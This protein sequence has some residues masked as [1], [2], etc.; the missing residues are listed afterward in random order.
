MARSF[1]APRHRRLLLAALAFALAVSLDVSGRDMSVWAQDAPSSEPPPAATPP[2]GQKSGEQKPPERGDRA[3]TPASAA[4]AAQHRL[5]PDSTTQQTL[6]LAGRTLAFAATAGSIRLFDDKGEPQAD[7]AYTA[8]QLDGADPATRPVTFVFNGGPGAASA[9]LQLGNAGPW[10]LPITGDAA[11]P[12]A[13]PDLQPNAETWLDFTDLVFIDPVGT[14]YSR[15]VATGE[16]VRKRFFSIDGDVSS[17]AV[18][19]RRWL[20]KSG[21][22]PSPKFVA[23]ESYGGI[24]GPKIVHELQINQGVGVKGLILISPVLDF[25]DFGG[26]SLLQY[27]ASL[28]TMAAVAR[29]AKSPVTRADMADVEHY[30]AGDFLTDLVKG[31]ADTEATT[32]LSDRFAALTGID[33]AVSRRLAGRFDSIEFRREFDRRDGKVT[34]RYDASVMGF[35]PYPDSSFFHFSDPSGEAL[36]APLSSAAVDLTTRKLNWRPDGSY[37]LL[38]GAVGKAWNFGNGIDPPESISQLRQ[39]LALD[40]RL[41]LLIG[42][43]LFDLATPYFGTTMQLDQLP[44]FASP[45]RVKLVVYPGGHMFYSRDASRQAFRTEVQALMK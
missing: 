9:Y 35:D 13:S 19:I 25:R 34:G 17:I 32:R 43:G 15:F 3:D 28:P 5:P 8:Y 36:T 16:D 44:A 21:R 39:I 33:Q 41:K 7:I 29:N 11:V 45:D 1:A 2:A 22:L 24:R 23:T 12:S 31:L 38:N 42:H 26:S 4:V 14:G 40:P 18:T 6:A 37:Q 27:V 10:R 20:E 30:A